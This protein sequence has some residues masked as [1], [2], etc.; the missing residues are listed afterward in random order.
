MR[1]KARKF[2]PEG[3]PVEVYKKGKKH[4]IYVDTVTK[5]IIM[6][7]PL[8]LM[9]AVAAAPYVIEGAQA[10]FSKKGKSQPSEMSPHYKPSL[11]ERAIMLEALENKKG[12]CC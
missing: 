2:T 7:N 1:K 4:K 6:V 3:H 10:L 9:A 11:M 8:P 5:E 12:R